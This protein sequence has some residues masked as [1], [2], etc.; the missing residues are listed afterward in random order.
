MNTHKVYVL[1]D[2][3]N[4]KL[5]KNKQATHLEFALRRNSATISA[6]GRDPKAGRVEVFI[7]EKMLSCNVSSMLSFLKK[8]K[9]KLLL[10]EGRG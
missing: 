6:V 1:Y 3:N 7:M 8:K 9:K 5:T 10:E 4:Q 2:V